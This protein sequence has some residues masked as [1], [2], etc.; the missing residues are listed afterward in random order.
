MIWKFCPKK[1]HGIDTVNNAVALAVG[2]KTFSDVLRSMNLTVGMYARAC[3]ELQ[4]TVHI[5]KAQNEAL[6]SSH[7]A[8]IA[9]RESRLRR[10]EQKQEAEGFPYLAGAYAE[11]SLQFTGLKSCRKLTLIIGLRIISSKLF[12]THS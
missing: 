11:V 9:R 3:F 2:A 7:A 8:R 1:N 10:N 12:H 4:D 6:E 5:K